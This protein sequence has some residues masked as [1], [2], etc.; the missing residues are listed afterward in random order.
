MKYIGRFIFSG[1]RHIHCVTDPEHVYS[2]Y[3]AVF[4]HGDLRLYRHDQ[5]NGDDKIQGI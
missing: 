1:H 4:S 3:N 2:M 5:M